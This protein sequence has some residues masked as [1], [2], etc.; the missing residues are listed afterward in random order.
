MR[1]TIGVCM[2]AGVQG[3]SDGLRQNP[4]E[5]LEVGV[6]LGGELV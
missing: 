3:V 1:R 4:G 2:A 6:V 5:D